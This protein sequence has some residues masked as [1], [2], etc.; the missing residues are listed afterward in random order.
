MHDAAVADL[1][2]LAVKRDRGYLI[3]LVLMLLVGFVACAFLW[4]GMTNSSTK[5]CVAETLVGGEPA[6]TPPEP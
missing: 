1:E 5:G 4:Q 6:A 2:K 3:R